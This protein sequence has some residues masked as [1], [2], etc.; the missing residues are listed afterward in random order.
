MMEGSTTATQQPLTAVIVGTG[1]GG[2]G[3]AIKLR[4]AGITDFVM[5]EKSD[6]IG[7]T[8]RD[9]TYPGAAC[10]VPSPLYS[11]SFEQDFDWP[12]FYSGQQDIHRN[13]QHCVTKYKLIPH[14]RLN[15]EV[16]RTAFDERRGLLGD[17]NRRQN[18]Q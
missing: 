13:Q 6:Q 11:F 5:L 2:I 15:T 1:F 10:D 3:M 14:V 18:C 17:R 4:Q 9:N 8:W 16:R 12:R 7:G